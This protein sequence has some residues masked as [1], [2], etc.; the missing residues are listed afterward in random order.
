MTIH[1]EMLMKEIHM[2]CSKTKCLRNTMLLT[3]E[4]TTELTEK[5]SDFD[6]ETR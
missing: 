4:T 6:D 3:K 2:M 1:Y 5:V